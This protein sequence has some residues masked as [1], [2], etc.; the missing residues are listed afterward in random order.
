MCCCVLGVMC[1]VLVLEEMGALVFIFHSCLFKSRR[2]KLLLTSARG[3]RRVV[4]L[5]VLALCRG[6]LCV[7]VWGG[8]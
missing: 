4:A 8:G 6:R 1:K 2:Q 7:C 5:N 3:C